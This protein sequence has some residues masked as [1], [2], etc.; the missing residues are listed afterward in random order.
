MVEDLVG[1]HAGKHT[2]LNEGPFRAKVEF[3][4]ARPSV[5]A[6]LVKWNVREEENISTISSRSWPPQLED[7]KLHVEKGRCWNEIWATK[8]DGGEKPSRVLPLLC[9]WRTA[10]NTVEVDEV[11][12]PRLGPLYKRESRGYSSNHRVG[13]SQVLSGE[14]QL[15]IGHQH[16]DPVW[17]S[18]YS[19]SSRCISI[20]VAVWNTQSIER[21]MFGYWIRV[22]NAWS[23]TPL[24]YTLF[25]NHFYLLTTAP[26]SPHQYQ[27]A[28]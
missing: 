10:V 17:I 5:K 13:K 6:D 11:G 8:T 9:A 20:G 24:L 26:L 22:L 2:S 21:S 12:F 1:Y 14:A 19:A 7:Q 15:V 27:L 18:I 25:W 3:S 16:I 23:M 4:D 28:Y